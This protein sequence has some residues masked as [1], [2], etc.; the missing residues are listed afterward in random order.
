MLLICVFDLVSPLAPP[1]TSLSLFPSSLTSRYALPHR[2]LP[3][4]HRPPLG[5]RGPHNTN[6]QRVAA[7]LPPAPFP[8]SFFQRRR[9]PRLHERHPGRERG[10]GRVGAA[11]GAAGGAGGHA[12]AGGGGGRGG[13][14]GGGGGWWGEEREEDGSVCE[15][16]CPLGRALVGRGGGGR[17]RRRA[18][19][20]GRRKTQSPPATPFPAIVSP[21]PFRPRP[22]ARIVATLRDGWTLNWGANRRS[23]RRPPI[24]PSSP[25]HLRTPQAAA[26]PSPSRA[27]RPRRGRR[28]R[29]G[30]SRRRRRAGWRWRPLENSATGVG[31]PRSP[32][33]RLL[34]APPE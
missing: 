15:R 14:G 20:G 34:L 16:G 27:R 30:R 17:R 31:T 18:G 24:A 1:Q 8:S 23:I 19:R 4:P 33:S 7:A 6:G 5:R 25:S 3:R 9:P 26:P 21:P 13:G 12:A 29:A 11:G 2:P 28:G 10:A 22:M 32:V